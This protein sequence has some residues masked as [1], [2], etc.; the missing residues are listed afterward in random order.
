MQF[1]LLGTKGINDFNYEPFELKGKP[2]KQNMPTS[3][4]VSRYTAFTLW[5]GL[6]WRTVVGLTLQRRTDYLF[7]TLWSVTPAAQPAKPLMMLPVCLFFAYS[8]AIEQGQIYTTIQCSSHP[9]KSAYSFTSYLL[10]RESWD[11]HCW[12]EKHKIWAQ[13]CWKRRRHRMRKILTVL[14]SWII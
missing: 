10:S 6:L 1:R 5:A 7:M 11:R 9:D 8:S 3:G 12:E 13:L 2:V 14:M 4:T